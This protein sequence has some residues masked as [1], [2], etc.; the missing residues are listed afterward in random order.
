MRGSRYGSCRSNAG[1]DIFTRRAAANL[2]AG[3]H[4]GGFHHQIIRAADHDEMFDIVAAHQHQL[5]LPIKIKR[6]HNAKPGLARTS[7]ARAHAAEE[8]RP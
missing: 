1:G 2:L 4:D 5:T 6:I 3:T 8:E 7:T